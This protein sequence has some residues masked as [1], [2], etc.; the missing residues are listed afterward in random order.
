MPKKS[1][2]VAAA[3]AIAIGTASG[4]QAAEKISIMVGGI[5]K[6]I[7]LPA[8]L[9]EQL[10]YF[11]DEGLDVELLTEPAGVKPKTRC[12]RAR[13]R[14]LSGFY[15]HTIDLQSQGQV[16]RISGPVQPRAGRGGAGLDQASPTDQIAGRFQ[17][18]E[19]WA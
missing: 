19:T 12:W 17:G 11:K 16:R 2:F 14:A 6:H 13:S 5:E 3:L 7:Y 8:R 15:D 18:Q 9:A 10:G 4:A 1:L